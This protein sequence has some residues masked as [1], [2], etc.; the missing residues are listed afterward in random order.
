MA[1]IGEIERFS[2]S[3]TMNQE[4]TTTVDNIKKGRNVS[5]SQLRKIE[6]WLAGSLLHSNA[7]R[8]GA[9]TNATLAEYELATTSTIGR[10][11]YRTFFV[12]NHKTAVTGRAKLTMDQHLAKNVD[13]Y[14][15]QIRP[16]LDGS[17][18]H[19]LFPNR[20]GKKLD[21]LS[22]HIEKLSTNLGINLPRTATD[23]THA[24]ATAVAGSSGMERTAVAAAMSH[25]KQSQE[26]YYQA[27]KGKKDAVEG[28]RLMET[29]RREEKGNEGSSVRG[30]FTASEMST[31]K[32]YFE[33]RGKVIGLL[34]LFGHGYCKIFL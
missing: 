31:I 18:S 3:N 21:H 5:Q 12:E 10:A 29:M 22:R 32:D 13:M 25:S 34:D 19:L 1:K 8:P 14:V 24:T 11:T 23:T 16:H 17:A 9:V 15:R 7:Q 20:E 6:I 30:S 2:R 4:L 27:N 26:L 28:Y 33:Q